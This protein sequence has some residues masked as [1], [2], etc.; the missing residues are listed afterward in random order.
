MEPTW[1]LKK[2]IFEDVYIVATYEKNVHV[3]DSHEGDAI[4]DSTG[5]TQTIRLWAKR[6]KAIDETGTH[7]T[8]SGSNRHNCAFD[9]LRDYLGEDTVDALHQEI[10]RTLT[11]RLPE[12]LEV[13]SNK[14]GVDITAEVGDVSA[15]ITFDTE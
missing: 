8:V 5:E 14:R 11:T 7:Y 10:P 15:T 13:L 12:E 1:N 3:G 6:A 4:Y 2:A 9:G